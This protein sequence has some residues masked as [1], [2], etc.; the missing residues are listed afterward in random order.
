MFMNNKKVG[1][2]SF[3]SYNDF[4]FIRELVYDT[5][6]TCVFCVHDRN[7]AYLLVFQWNLE[8]FFKIKINAESYLMLNVSSISQ[9]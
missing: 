4:Q 8:L 3:P 9:V 6:L 7:P 1:N 5:A 2:Y